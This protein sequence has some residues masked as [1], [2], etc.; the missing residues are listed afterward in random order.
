MWKNGWVASFFLKASFEFLEY[1]I[2]SFKSFKLDELV[3]VMNIKLYPGQ[4]Q[5]HISRNLEMLPNF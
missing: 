4:Q 1:G 5:F 3:R 2:V